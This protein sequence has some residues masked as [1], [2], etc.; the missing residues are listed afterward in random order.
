LDTLEALFG[1]FSNIGILRAEL[2]RLFDWLKQRGVTT[3]IT[4]EQGHGAL[5]RHGLEEYVSDCVILLDHRVV[6]QLSARR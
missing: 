4:S 5:T 6:N 3:V 2:R 1:G